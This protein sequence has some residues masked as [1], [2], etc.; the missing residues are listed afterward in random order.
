[1]LQIFSLI[2]RRRL[3]GDTCCAC[4]HGPTFPVLRLLSLARCDVETV[5]FR[6]DLIDGGAW[7]WLEVGPGFEG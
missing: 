2:L 3:G 6:S 1:M 7:V 5:V 4:S